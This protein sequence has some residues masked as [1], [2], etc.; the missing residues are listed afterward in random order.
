MCACVCACACMCV[1]VW[2]RVCMGVMVYGGTCEQERTPLVT[3]NDKLTFERHIDDIL[4][5]TV[6]SFIS[7]IP[8]SRNR[9]QLPRS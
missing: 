3:V 8:C 9:T 6:V 2:A 1:C 7:M 5:L 4:H